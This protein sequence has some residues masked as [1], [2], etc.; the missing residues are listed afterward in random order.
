MNLPML[1][2]VLTAD[3]CPWHSVALQVAC[4]DDM[5][6]YVR[7]APLRSVVACRPKSELTSTCRDD[8]PD[9]FCLE[10]D[11][12]RRHGALFFAWVRPACT[13]CRTIFALRAT[14]RDDMRGY[15]RFEGGM[16]R[17]GSKILTH[18]GRWC[19]PAR[20]KGAGHEEVSITCDTLAPR[21]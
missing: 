2:L 17:R 19:E 8:M 18:C 12:S 1:G 6:P 5:P 15:V 21:M 11:V 14:C 4:R 9:Y 16:L 13:T 7:P 20:L 10:G 3:S